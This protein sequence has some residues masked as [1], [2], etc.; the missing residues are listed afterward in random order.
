M[1]T[2]RVGN[3][4]IVP[5]TNDDEIVERDIKASL[6]EVRD[7]IDGHIDLPNARDIVF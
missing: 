5:I 3:F 6:K 1:L 7:H 4:K 2:S